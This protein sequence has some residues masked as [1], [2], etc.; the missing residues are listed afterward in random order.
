MLSRRLLS[1]VAAVLTLVV[2]AYMLVLPSLPRGELA[3]LHR[4]PAGAHASK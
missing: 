4:A 3:A 1:I 2:L